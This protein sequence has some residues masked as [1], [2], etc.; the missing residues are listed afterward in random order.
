[1]RIGAFVIA[2]CT[3]VLPAI[4][5]AQTYSGSRSQ[6]AGSVLRPASTAGWRNYTTVPDGPC[7]PPMSVQ[8]DCYDNCR[9][10][11]PLHPL[12]FLH[13][14]GRMLDCLLPCNLC[15]G[16]GWG[17]GPYHGC[18]LG[19]RTWGHCGVCCGRGSYSGCGG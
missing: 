14:V 13:R 2:A 8:T 19:G 15:C 3:L 12:C 18:H 10:C 6:A 11:G 16:G 9:P 1:M 17:N 7:G 5:A 4:A